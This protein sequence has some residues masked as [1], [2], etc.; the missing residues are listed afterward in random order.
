MASALLVLPLGLSARWL[1][2]APAPLTHWSLR[3]ARL[4]SLQGPQTTVAERAAELANR[5][6]RSVGDAEEELR[7]EVATSSKFMWRGDGLRRDFAFSRPARQRAL[8][9]GALENEKA[10]LTAMEE[11]QTAGLPREYM[12]E[13]V[14]VL[15]ELAVVR[16]EIQRHYLRA[17]SSSDAAR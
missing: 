9:R 10:L 8:M 16:A 2:V 15:A 7:V 13:A 12:E 11:A 1:P 14:R 6:R 5:L 17:G 3:A 4:T